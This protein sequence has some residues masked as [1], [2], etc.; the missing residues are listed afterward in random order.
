M[1]VSEDRY[2]RDRLRFDLA[3]RM[4][5]HGARTRTIRSWTGLTDDRLRKLYRSYT[6]QRSPGPS[7]YRTSI[8]VPRH[9]GF[10][11]R[12]SAL[13]FEASTLAC[14]FYIVGLVAAD[15]E[16]LPISPAPSSLRRAETFCRAYEI[17]RMLYP[18]SR[19]S[20][21]HAWLLLKA[22][23]AKE[24]VALSTCRQ[25]HRLYVTDLTC[26]D[27]SSCGCGDR[28]LALPRRRRTPLRPAR[29]R[30]LHAAVQHDGESLQQTALAE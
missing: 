8:R 20:F 23:T 13:R 4:L 11:L 29:G 6:R 26:I 3:M 18:V 30:L 21:E 27:L 1:R 14:F 15:E 17:H 12:S 25:C 19:L 10:F 9:A 28:R 24:G 7:T 5:R 22:L 2:N 16:C